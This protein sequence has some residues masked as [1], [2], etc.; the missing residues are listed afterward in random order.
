MVSGTPTGFPSQRPGRILGEMRK[1]PWLRSR[2]GLAGDARER[3]WIVATAAVAGAVV[4]HAVAYAAAYPNAGVREVLLGQTGHRYGSTAIAVAIVF[5]AIAA[6]GTVLAH[7]RRGVATAAAAEPAG[8]WEGFRR[9]ALRL[10]L[11]QVSIFAVQE[12]FERV[13]AGAPVSGL[14]HGPF[15]TVGL[16]VQILVAASIALV[17]AFLGRAAEVIGRAL[18]PERSQRRATPRFGFAA[19]HALPVSPRLGP[20]LSRAPPATSLSI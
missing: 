16:A 19:A 3:R 17:L 7:V 6:A 1:R 14:L 18:A 10:A 11:L 12:I 2:D 4:G 8:W 15:L 5:G 9:S 20:R 13:L